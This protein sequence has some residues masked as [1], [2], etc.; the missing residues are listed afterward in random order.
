ML[1]PDDESMRS[2]A[3]KVAIVEEGQG[4]KRKGLLSDVDISDL[5]DAAIV[6]ERREDLLEAT[7]QSLVQGLV[8]GVVLYRAIAH[9]EVDDDHGKIGLTVEI[10]SERVWPKYRLKPKTITN[11]VLPRFKCVALFW[12]AFVA[13]AL[14]GEKTFPCSILDLPLFLAYADKYRE[15]GELT[16]TPHSPRMLL[17]PGE[18]VV[19]P[20]ATLLPKVAALEFINFDV[21]LPRQLGKD[22]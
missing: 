13:S 11:Q 18:S 1:W 21:T 20:H 14:K 5:L 12:A 10:L 3:M 2:R 16:R 9:S 17:Q 7:K 15:Q 19:I 4:L 8:A 6:T 22:G